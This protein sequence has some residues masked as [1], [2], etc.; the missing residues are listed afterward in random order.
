MKKIVLTGGG[1]AGHV[2]PN[3]ALLPSLKEAG[4]E[5]FYIGSYTGIEKTLIEDLGIPYYGISSCKLRRY[6]SLKNLSDPFRVLHGLFQ[7]KRLM[8]KIKP[9]IVFSKGGFVSVPVVL[10]AGSRHIPVIIH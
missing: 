5:V 7:A 6:R 1:T 2:T 10:A 8:K 3:I 4:Y 9:D